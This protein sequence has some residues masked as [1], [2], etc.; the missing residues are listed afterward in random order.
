MDIEQDLFT[1]TYWKIKEELDTIR[2]GH[3]WLYQEVIVDTNGGILQALDA[4]SQNWIERV[5][6]L[7]ENGK[8]EQR[9]MKQAVSDHFSKAE[10]VYV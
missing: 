4:M 8:T 9:A 10:I 7:G 1:V 3:T 5:L 2:Y 6:P